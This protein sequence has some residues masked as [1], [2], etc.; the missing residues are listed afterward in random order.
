MTQLE[1][2]DL[3]NNLLKIPGTIIIYNNDMSS[4]DYVL[5]AH[6]VTLPLTPATSTA[7]SAAS[8]QSV[9]DLNSSASIDTDLAGSP[10]PTYQSTGG[11][12]LHHPQLQ[13]D[14]PASILMETPGCSELDQSFG[15]VGYSGPQDD[16]T[17]GR[18]SS[19]VEEEMVLEGS[20]LED[21]PDETDPGG[22]VTLV[23][24]E[25][26]SEPELTNLSWL[27]EL[28][29]ITNLTPSDVPLTDLPTARFNKF[30]AQVRRSRETYDKRKEQYTSPASS[31]EK[32][33]FNYAQ[34][35]AM[36]ML[37]EG[38][39]TL[40]QICKWIQ[41]KFSYYKVH[42][43]WN[44]SI[45]HNLS[46]SFFFTKV[47]RAKDEK[48]KG[49]YWELSMDVSKSERRRIRIRQRNKGSNITNNGGCA[50]GGNN[51]RTSTAPRMPKGSSGAGGSEA[52]GQ[53]T[54]N[55]NNNERTVNNN[56]TPDKQ[57]GPDPTVPCEVIEQEIVLASSE[58][59]PC[60]T[61]ATLLTALDSNNNSC[62]QQQQSIIPVPIGVTNGEAL[63]VQIDIIDNYSKPS[64]G[65]DMIVELPTPD[66]TPVTQTMDVTE[67]MPGTGSVGS[68]LVAQTTV[69]PDHLVVNED[70]LIHASALVEN[71]TI[72]FDSIMNGDNGASI[73]SSLNVDEIFSDNE[74][75]QPANDDIIVPF[76]SNVQQVQTGPNVVVETIPYYLPDMG[77]FDE[78]DFG[79]LINI[80]EQEISDEFL[81]E[82]GF[83]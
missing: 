79:N 37:E 5:N 20:E 24:D 38:R 52:N 31:L 62:P 45:R 47:Q 30:I 83:L 43:N 7:G 71:C 57:P 41:E 73:F 15:S 3:L 56:L 26:D 40:K 12:S 53:A 29:N 58:T 60:P 72:N 23:A 28:K 21:E 59:V 2:D 82:H 18:S 61:G 81:N 48:G 39:M 33:P 54:S 9:D 76:F 77:N 69:P 46:L 70:Q 13:P 17:T 22:T 68:N 74:I 63:P 64:S 65:M 51:R 67:E 66:P 36:A 75:P 8:E 34:I 14:S 55:N 42:K 78:S 19:H 11:A 35:I 49:G 1:D 32:P 4:Y 6:N 27:T 10:V 16:P 25:E 50:A 80:N 44:N